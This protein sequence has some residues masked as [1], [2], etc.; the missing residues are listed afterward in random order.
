MH[1]EMSG[2][3]EEI[4]EKKITL[5]LC[6][7]FGVPGLA[8]LTNTVGSF[9]GY[10]LMRLANIDFS[11]TNPIRANNTNLTNTTAAPNRFHPICN[12]ATT[13]ANTPYQF[14]WITCVGT[15]IGFSVLTATKLFLTC[16]CATP[17]SNF[18]KALQR[19]MHFAALSNIPASAVFPFTAGFCFFCLNV[20]DA[21]R[22]AGASFFGASAL[23]LFFGM[24]L[25]FGKAGENCCAQN[26]P[27]NPEELQVVNATA[28]STLRRL[29]NS[30]SQQLRSPRLIPNPS[31]HQTP[32]LNPLTLEPATTTIQAH[33]HQR[34]ETNATDRTVAFQELS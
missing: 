18:K 28:Q 34:S 27:E 15:A 30:S 3:F 7:F 13:N 14:A 11:A 33:R 9:F 21:L 32:T 12:Q 22:L 16:A 20:V 23:M 17:Q 5:S 24:I 2:D 4:Y 8:T 6:Y 10:A 26:N 31:P 29:S 19:A 25:L 1:K